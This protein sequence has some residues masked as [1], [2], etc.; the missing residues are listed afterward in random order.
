MT[1]SAVA[2]SL[3][4]LPTQT[5][6]TPSEDETQH[7]N[8]PP[9]K[10]VHP[11]AP[12][13]HQETPKEMPIQTGSVDGASTTTSP[14]TTPHPIA[15][16][17]NPLPS[18]TSGASYTEKGYANSAS[19]RTIGTGNAPTHS[20]HAR[21]ATS[22][23]TP[24]W[25]VAQNKESPLPTSPNDNQALN[26][27]KAFRGTHYSPS[28]LVVRALLSSNTPNQTVPSQVWR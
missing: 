10:A 14:I 28:R 24:Y 22:T 8:A 3:L 27:P 20:P 12:S 1:P 6:Q 5:P 7:P 11:T 21:C 9:P 17:S 18:Q 15:E 13:P 25:D 19:G 4:R 2:R 16:H 26:A 23:T